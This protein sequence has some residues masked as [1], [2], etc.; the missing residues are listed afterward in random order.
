MALPL[1]PRIVPQCPACIRSYAFGLANAQR[2]GLQQQIRGKKKM[3]NNS[4]IITVRLLKDVKAY[5]RKGK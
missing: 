4:G 1:R 3:P 5:G 2:S